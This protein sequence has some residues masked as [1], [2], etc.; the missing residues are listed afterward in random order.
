MRQREKEL[1]SRYGLEFPLLNIPD[2][3]AVDENE[4]QHLLRSLAELREDLAKL[5]WFDRVNREA[6]FKLY[7]KA[8]RLSGL[9]GSEISS[10][11]MHTVYALKRQSEIERL[12]KLEEKIADSL[13]NRHS[14]LP[15]HSLCLWKKAYPFAIYPA[16]AYQT[17]IDDDAA[18]LADLLTQC[19]IRDDDADI[20]YP[21]MLSQLLLFCIVSRSWECCKT[22]LL[23]IESSNRF[24]WNTDFLN[25]L[26]TSQGRQ[27]PINGSDEH[28]TREVETSTASSNLW[29]NFLRSD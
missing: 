7:D 5:Q 3:E 29:S 16:P 4:L 20:Q 28:E 21:D 12:R 24:I 11:H 25:Q 14:R 15:S 1:C 17:I 19:L 2:L 13:Q 26:L 6:I 23:S 22:V 18:S 27:S 9:S 8:W 10:I